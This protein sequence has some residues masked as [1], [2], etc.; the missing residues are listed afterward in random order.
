M[1]TERH[2]SDLEKLFVAARVSEALVVG[3]DTEFTAYRT[4]MAELAVKTGC[5]RF[6]D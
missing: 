3:D 5:R 2:P 4:Q 6:T 1:L